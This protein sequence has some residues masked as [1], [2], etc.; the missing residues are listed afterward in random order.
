MRCSQLSS[1]QPLEVE[2]NHETAEQ[3]EE[4]VPLDPSTVYE[5]AAKGDDEA[6]A[7]LLKVRFND[8]NNY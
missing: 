6:L 8:N 1:E 2:D 4:D 3:Q 5:L 7:A